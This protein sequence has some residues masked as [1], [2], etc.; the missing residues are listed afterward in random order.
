M[1]VV[2]FSN[3]AKLEIKFSDHKDYDSFKKAVLAIKHPDM[4]TNT[5]EGFKVALSEMFS[6]STGMRP[7][8]IPKNLIYLT[9][10]ACSK[11]PEWDCSEERFKE[12]GIRFEER[13]IRK[14]GIG[15]G[16]AINESEIVSFVEKESFFKEDNFYKIMSKKFRS[17]LSI[18]DGELNLLLLIFI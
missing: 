9:D 14:I 17:S 5:L 7:D 13:R 18:C 15:I 11:I 10:G 12:F 6:E 16:P 2:V 3:E 1:A 4:G 8:E